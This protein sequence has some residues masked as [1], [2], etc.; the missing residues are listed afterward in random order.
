MCERCGYKVVTRPYY[1][2]VTSLLSMMICVAC[3]DELEN[4]YGSRAIQSLPVDKMFPAIAEQL[5]L[6]LLG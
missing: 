1:Y 6:P 4:R 2:P 5:C 3:A